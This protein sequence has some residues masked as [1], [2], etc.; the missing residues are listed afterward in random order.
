MINAMKEG[1]S[2]IIQAECYVFISDES[3]NVPPLLN[4]ARTQVNALSY[5]P[6]SPQDMVNQW[7]GS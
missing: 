3:V 4:T 2:A 5:L 1:T 7:S 6:P